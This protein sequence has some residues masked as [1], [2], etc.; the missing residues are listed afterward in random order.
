MWLFWFGVVQNTVGY[1]VDFF[2]PHNEKA[3]KQGIWRHRKERDHLGDINILWLHMIM[4]PDSH[5]FGP[6]QLCTLDYSIWE[7]RNNA[8]YRASFYRG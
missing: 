5:T 8:Y 1:F 6:T 7:H 3:P 4:Q 2:I